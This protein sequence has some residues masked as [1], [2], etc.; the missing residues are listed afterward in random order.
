[1]HVISTTQ[2]R[3]QFS[4]L[5]DHVRISRRPVAIGR[6][7]RAEV[8]LIKFS[9]QMNSELDDITNINQT[10]GSFDFL[11]QEPDLYTKDDLIQSY[12]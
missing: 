1:M 3:K 12:V 8:L 5:I 11:E 7:D 10:S 2:A 4:A 9:E 6:R